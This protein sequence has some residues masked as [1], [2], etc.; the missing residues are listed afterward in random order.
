MPS[1][2]PAPDG[3][4]KMHRAFDV[5]GEADDGDTALGVVDELRPDVVLVDIRLPTTN[6]IELASQI[7]SEHPSTI[8]LIL[9]AYD[10]SDYVEAAMAAGV[11]GYLLKTTPSDELVRLIREA[12]EGTGRLGARLRGRWRERPRPGQANPRSD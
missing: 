7:V 9:S 8:V 10:D 12:C 11:S 6:G 4:S 5:V 2:G 3:S 1:F